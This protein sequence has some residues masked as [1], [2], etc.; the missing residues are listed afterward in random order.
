MDKRLPSQIQDKNAKPL[1]RDGIGK[2]QK[3][4]NEVVEP[5]MEEIQH[6]EDEGGKQQEKMVKR[7]RPCVSA[8]SAS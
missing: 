5:Q 3:N 2:N 1:S 7:G 4:T 6:E 8:N